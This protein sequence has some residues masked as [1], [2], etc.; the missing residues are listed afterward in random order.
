MAL[1]SFVMSKVANYR[2]QAL[3]IYP[4]AMA[5][6]AAV[7]LVSMAFLF[8]VSSLKSIIWTP[9]H[10]RGNALL[11]VG[12]CALGGLV[13]GLLN[14]AAQRDRVAAHDL[15]E[16]ISDMEEMEVKQP[17]SGRVIFGRASLGIVSLGFGGPLGPEAPVIALVSQLSS[18][19]SGVMRMARDRAVELSVAGS[20]GVLF[21]VPLVLTGIEDDAKY[22]GK[23]AVQKLASRGPEILAAI[24]SLAVI[25]W[26]LP[27]AGIHAFHSEVSTEIGFSWGLI[28]VAIVAAVA[29][30]L[31]RVLA[32]SLPPIRHY[33]VE[34]LPGGPVPIGIVSGLI[35]GS[36]SLMSPLILFS[37]HHEIQD[38]LDRDFG[39]FQLLL[40]ALLKL[41]VVVVC[42]AG[43]W[44]GGQIFPLAFIG[45]ALGLAINEFTNSSA[46]L[47]FAAAG[48]VAASA[49][50]IRKPVLA[51]LLGLLLFPKETWIPMLLATVIAMATTDNS[52]KQH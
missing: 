45:S 40:L 35:L 6:G 32:T 5:L 49:V 42:L 19:L 18:R 52:A 44:Y 8:L 46:P 20:L 27:G 29:S 14:Q 48:F 38:M 43:G 13:V 16:A 37:G 23:N 39:G 3:K 41:F 11:V 50:G 9:E 30:A 15:T 51:L 24:S 7:G 36:A 31:G 17:P 21:G 34:K 2:L 28:W 1:C 10:F 4:I 47:A 26:L 22:E 33:F 12:I 25:T